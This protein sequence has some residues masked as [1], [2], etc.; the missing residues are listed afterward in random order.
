MTKRVYTA[1]IIIAAALISVGAFGIIDAIGVA[2][3]PKP[4]SKD[5]PLI[6]L[7]Y[8]NDVVSKQILDH[9]TQEL[10]EKL[11]ELE[12][13][14]RDGDAAGGQTS[15]GFTVVSLASGQRLTL[16]AGSEAVLRIGAAKCVTSLS[17]GLIDVTDALVLENGLEL[18]RNHLYI[19]TI[20]G[21]GIEA[22]DSATL[23]VRGA[24]TVS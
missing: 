3:A 5:D 10:D 15:R 11:A 9:T 1:L 14:L 8:L 7:S 24:Y 13:R 4:G 17:P 16:S 18:I 12:T 19:A 23:V 22:P 21:R 2:A 20:E 6:T